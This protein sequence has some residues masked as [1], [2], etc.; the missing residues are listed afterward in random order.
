MKRISLIAIG[1]IFAA[2]FS[3]PAFAQ[4]N[5]T[6]PT[7]TS[8]GGDK[9]GLIAWGAF[10]DQTKGIKRYASA[11]ALLDKEFEPLRTEIRNMGTKYEALRK[12][13]EGF[14]ELIKQNKPVPI[15]Q[16]EINKKV[17]E[18]G[19]LERDIKRKQEDAQARY[20]SQWELRISPIEDDILKALSEY[21]TQKNYA[22]ILDG[23]KMLEAGILLA[24]IPRANITEDFIAFYNARPT[25][26]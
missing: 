2:L 23:G 12:E 26:K 5:T 1:L 8:T 18:L 19:Q 20:Q 22:A 7:N 24:S 11:I 6:T 9:I 21:A 14:Q 4:T 17:E 3:V 13:L 25:P 15:P 16:S 10:Q